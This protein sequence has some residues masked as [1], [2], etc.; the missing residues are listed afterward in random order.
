MILLCTGL[1]RTGTTS[2]HCALQRLGFSSMHFVP[3]RIDINNPP[4]DWR[5]FDD[6]DCVLDVPASHYW[7]ELYEEYECKVILTIRSAERWWRS[8]S[9]Q[10]ESVH[11]HPFANR[12]F[13][14]S[15]MPD[16]AVWIRN[17]ALHNQAVIRAVPDDMLL[18]MNVCGGDGW[19]SL[20]PFVADLLG[21]FPKENEWIP[22]A[23]SSGSASISVM[24]SE[25]WTGQTEETRNSVDASVNES[26]PT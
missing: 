2:L 12:L 21:D 24:Q 17:M 13:F 20:L 23:A 6:V 15:S 11:P 16:K 8:I 18:V 10:V 26:L 5:I 4:T 9:R 3:E 22:Q 25:K 19:A 7:R 14:G 1:P